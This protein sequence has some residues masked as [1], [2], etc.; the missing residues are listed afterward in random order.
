MG[1]GC[2]LEGGANGVGERLPLVCPHLAF[3][4]SGP[5]DTLPMLLQARDPAPG[6]E[7]LSSPQKGRG[8]HSWSVPVLPTEGDRDTSSGAVTAGLSWA[9]GSV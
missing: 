5:V 9:A 4:A 8:P 7:R 6:W 2:A 3:P 1:E